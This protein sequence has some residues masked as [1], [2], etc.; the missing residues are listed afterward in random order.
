M[1]ALCLLGEKGQLR[2]SYERNGDLSDGRGDATPPGFS[3]VQDFWL[4]DVPS[5]LDGSEFFSSLWPQ[6]HKHLCLSNGRLYLL[7]TRS[8]KGAYEYLLTGISFD[9]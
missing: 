9:T 7:A 6:H 5:L 4:D 3:K 1:F 2:H 8:L